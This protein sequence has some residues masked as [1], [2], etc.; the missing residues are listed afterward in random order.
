MAFLDKILVFFIPLY[1]LFS[2]VVYYINIG[3]I[4]SLRYS[5]VNIFIIFAKNCQ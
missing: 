1:L 2:S 5:I 3:F 4:L